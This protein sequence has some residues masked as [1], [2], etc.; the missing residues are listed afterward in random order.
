[1]KVGLLLL[2]C[3]WPAL[4]TAADAVQPQELSVDERLRLI[5]TDHDGQVSVSEIRAYLEAKHGKGYEQTLLT[6]M[7]TKANTS[8]GSP[9]SR[10]FY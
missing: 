2:I 6:E 1:M 4:G 8:C 5:D 7:E 9:F 10:S 3:L